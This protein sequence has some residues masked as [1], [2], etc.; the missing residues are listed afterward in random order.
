[1]LIDDTVHLNYILTVLFCFGI[2][3]FF[4]PVGF[5]SYW[6]SGVEVFEY[7]GEFTCFSLHSIG[8]ASCSL[9]LYC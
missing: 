8:F 4:L 7:N 5:I 1:M 6:K 2:V 3:V 9:S